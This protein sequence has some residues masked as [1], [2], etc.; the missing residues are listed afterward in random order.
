MEE[1][2][3]VRRFNNFRPTPALIVAIAALAVAL[4]GAAYAAIPG[5]GVIH[6]CYNSGG[7]LKVI[8]TATAPSC[9]KG[10]T[11]L[12]WNQRGPQGP[13]GQQGPAGPA[14]APGAD[15]LYFAQASGQVSLSE[16]PISSGPYFADLGGPSVTVNVPANSIVKFR[17]SY[18]GQTSPDQFGNFAGVFT[19]VV[20]KTDLPPGTSPGIGRTPSD[21][22]FHTYTTYDSGSGQY[23]Y[24]ASPGQHT[25]T[26]E[27]EEVPVLGIGGQTGPFP[28]ALFQNR[29]LWVQVISPTNGS[30]S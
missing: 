14:G 9:P 8:D 18:E 28:P 19:E 23:E 4:G 6:G 20:D 21:A 17:V 11:A 13:Q 3:K 26:L 2:S 10:Y 5:N 25:Y 24:F 27:Y 22:N 29:K 30:G 16:Q 1:K 15:Q 12:T 7:N